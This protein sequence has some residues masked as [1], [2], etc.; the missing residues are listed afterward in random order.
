MGSRGSITQAFLRAQ[1]I[2]SANPQIFALG[3]KEVWEVKHPL[4]RVVHT[5]GWPLPTDAFG[6]SFMY[7][8]GERQVAIGLVVGAMVIM[9]IMLVAVAERTREIGIRKALGAK[10]RDIM[11]QFL[12]EAS[13]LSVA[14][15]VFGDAVDHARRQTVGDAQQARVRQRRDRHHRRR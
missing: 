10:R 9:N 5:L 14:G 7:P 11:A 1:S 6:G 12:V 8:L 3:V 4:D 15:A 2:G 13:A